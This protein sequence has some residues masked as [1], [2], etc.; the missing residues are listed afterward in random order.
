MQG[1]RECQGVRRFGG[2]RGACGEHRGKRIGDAQVDAFSTARRSVKRAP[3]HPDVAFAAARPGAADRLLLR[4]RSGWIAA[5]PVLLSVPRAWAAAAAVGMLKF[6]KMAR[7]RD[8]RRAHRRRGRSLHAARALSREDKLD[9]LPQLWNVLRGDMSLVGPRPED[10]GSSSC[11]RAE[12]RRDPA[13]PPRNHGALQ[14]AFARESERPRSR[15]PARALRRADPA[16]EGRGSTASMSRG[17]R[18]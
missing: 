6:R 9:E 16:A 8:R 10:R 1:G 5:G 2:A 11:K 15:R 7:R 18:S 4:S 12:Y 13:G 3:R 17:A 14:L